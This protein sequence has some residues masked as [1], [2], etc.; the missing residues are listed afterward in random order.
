MKN[1][2][3]ITICL[4]FILTFANFAQAQ[5]LVGTLRNVDADG[6]GCYVSFKNGGLLFFDSWSGDTWMNIDGRDV[7]LSLVKKTEPKGRLKVG[8]RITRRYSVGNATVDTVEIVRKL[9]P[10]SVSFT[11][12]VRK[13]N[14]I[15]VVKAS[16]SCGD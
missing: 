8:S 3:K 4:T 7:R 15:Q 1:L 10:M 13:G 9:S 2:I 12:T 6:P 16:G 14:R 5:N 11:F